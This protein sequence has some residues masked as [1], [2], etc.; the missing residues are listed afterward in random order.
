[1]SVRSRAPAVPCAATLLALGLFA[2]L[3]ETWGGVAIANAAEQK[4]AAMRNGVN[5]PR[6]RNSAP[7]PQSGSAA[8]QF[9][10][11]LRIIAK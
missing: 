9:T 1:M 2:A 7:A 10:V 8:R 3:T 6:H 4:S 11:G 5:V